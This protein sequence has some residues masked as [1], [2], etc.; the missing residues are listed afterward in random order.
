LDINGGSAIAEIEYYFQLR[1][2]DIAHSLALVSVF[3]PP[4][5]ELLDISHHTTYVCHYLGPD[6]LKVVDVKAIKALVAMVPDYQVTMDG[7][8]V[9][10]ENRFF[11]VELPFLKF[12][13]MTTALD[14]D[15]DGIDFTTD[16]VN[17]YM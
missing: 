2:D 6:A 7:N 16:S 13:A 1:F 3:S 11:L 12:A 8:I 15:D 5:Q 9:I 4:D 10:P 14:E 17:E